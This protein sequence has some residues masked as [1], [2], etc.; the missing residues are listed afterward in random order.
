MIN[1]DEHETTARL[2]RAQEI[3]GSRVKFD[4]VAQLLEKYPLKTGGLIVNSLGSVASHPLSLYNANFEGL[5][6]NIGRDADIFIPTQQIDYQPDWQEIV[7]VGLVSDPNHEELLPI[8]EGEMIVSLTGVPA[9][10]LSPD[11][12]DCGRAEIDMMLSRYLCQDIDPDNTAIRTNSVGETMV[13][14]GDHIQPY[15]Q[16][17]R[18]CP[19]PFLEI[20]FLHGYQDGNHHLPS[21]EDLLQNIGYLPGTGNI[22]FGSKG[23]YGYG[24][25][26]T[27]TST[28]PAINWQYVDQSPEHAILYL[29]RMTKGIINNIFRYRKYDDLSTL[30]NSF[31]L[32][33]QEIFSTLDFSNF[34]DK[35]N[36]SY[37]K[38]TKELQEVDPMFQKITEYRRLFTPASTRPVQLIRSKLNILPPVPITVLD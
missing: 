24:E 8:C 31:Q 30:V 20:M 4:W 5:R 38:L 34:T 9:I 28:I 2:Y 7:N 35:Q 15:S 14:V 17:R 25:W 16:D 32:A 6:T 33:M 36:K 29:R 27:P 1:T 18:R 11:L 13:L 3:L 22:G 21:N 26:P 19:Q 37:G 10:Y 12:K 23:E